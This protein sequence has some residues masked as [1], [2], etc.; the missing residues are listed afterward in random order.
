MDKVVLM[1]TPAWT[2][3]MDKTSVGER[4]TF[5]LLA[6]SAA[7]LLM[8]ALVAH[9]KDSSSSSDFM[10]FYTAGT[11]LKQGL[12]SQLYD[13]SAQMACQ[14]RLFGRMVPVDVYDH[15]PFE[16]L[17]YW[18]LAY[19]PYR[20]AYLLWDLLSLIMLGWSLYLLKPYVGNF[21]TESRLT[22]TL[23]VL[24][25]LISTLREGQ[26]EILL[27][28]TCVGA[29]ICLKKG[30]EYAAGWALG[31]GLFRFQFI[32]PLLLVFLALKRWRIILGS[33]VAGVLLGLLSLALLGGAGIRNYL[34]LLLR[35]AKRDAFPTLV[36][37]MPN[38]RGFIDV[39]LAGR[40]AP[41]HL[42]ILV[43]VGSL[44][45][46]AWPI[47]KWRRWGWNPGAKVFDI[48]FSLSMVVSVMISYH[49]L[50][51]SLLV[52]ILPALLLLD[53]AARVQQGG[54][55]RWRAILP[56]LALFVMAVYLNAAGN[57]ELSFLF[58]PV[59]WFAFA[60]AAQIPDNEP[61]RSRILTTDAVQ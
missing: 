48:S 49:S 60:I 37:A 42:T 18:P 19:L 38:L 36:P 8:F 7:A 30:R 55:G 56:L 35:L 15:P 61:G 28:L 40:L 29:F 24:Y 33:A 44:T 6:A 1:K 22:L 47:V 5:A 50:I 59:L 45:L 14:R 20:A 13:E 12:G 4:I 9:L 21:D 39:L 34:E 26:N 23:A 25:P 54:L 41:L 16:T 3:A 11:L 31:A 57:N 51:H 17:I 53:Q 10:G 2:E 46:L 58:A 32:L 43:A 52:L 27:L